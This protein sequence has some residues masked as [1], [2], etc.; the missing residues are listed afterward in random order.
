MWQAGWHF[1]RWHHSLCFLY[2]FFV[3]IFSLPLTSVQDVSLFH[4]FFWRNLFSPFYYCSSL[5]A[6][7]YWKIWWRDSKGIRRNFFICVCVS[8]YFPVSAILCCRSD[9]IFRLY[10]MCGIFNCF[11]Y[12]P[13]SFRYL[14]V[15]LPW[16]C[17]GAG[18][19]TSLHILCNKMAI[20]KTPP[21]LS[22]LCLHYYCRGCNAL[23]V[24]ECCV[25]S[26]AARP[27]S[28]Q[29]TSAPKT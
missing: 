10:R 29:S 11:D 1:T 2:L 25:P 7:L 13:K 27:R 21:G 20:K 17:P 6:W 15:S 23:L 26:T 8:S 24:T 5:I 16:Q 19:R 14:G 22:A 9:R 4:L 28:P 18:A 12:N 3:I